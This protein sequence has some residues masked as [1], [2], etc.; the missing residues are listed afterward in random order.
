MPELLFRPLYDENHRTLVFNE[1]D[2]PPK[3]IQKGLREPLLCDE[4]EKHL[5][6]YE[7]Y[8]ARFWYKKR[9]IPRQIEGPEVLVNFDYRRFKLFMLSIVWRAAVSRLPEFAAVTLGKH[10]EVVRGMVLEDR[11]GGFLDYPIFAG[12]VV[13][14]ETKGICDNVMLQPLKIKA[15]SHWAIRMVFAGAS[16]TVLTSSHQSLPFEEKFLQDDGQLTFLTL[17]LPEFAKRSGMAE[18]IHDSLKQ[19]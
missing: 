2:A 12:L 9:P 15:R 8:F 18:A 1:R 17:S 4:C 14:P 16:W 5:Q 6:R 13:D 11:P 7:D 19:L 10:E 3:T